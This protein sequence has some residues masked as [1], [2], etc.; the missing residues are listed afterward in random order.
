LRQKPEVALRF[1]VA[2]GERLNQ[3]EEQLAEVAFKRIPARLAGLLLR[4]MEEHEGDRVL[5]GYT[6]QHLADILGT[7]RETVSQTLNEFRQEN[8]IQT[9]RKRIE[10]HD[11]DALQA[12]AAQ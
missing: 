1:L 4:L 6:H 3:M 2:V 9:Y 12:I 5:R 11:A 8:I 10:I 7:Y